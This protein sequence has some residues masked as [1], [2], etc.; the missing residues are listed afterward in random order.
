MDSGPNLPGLPRP[1][2]AACAPDMQ[3]IDLISAVRELNGLSSRELNKLL[4]ESENFTIQFK[5]L[6][7]L[8]EAESISYLDE[9]AGSQKTMHLANSV[10]LEFLDSLKNVFRQEAKQLGDS[11]DKSSRMGLVLLNALRLA[12]IFSDDSNFRSFFMTNTI[13]V[14]AEIFAIP[15]DEFLSSWCSV[16][17]PMIEEDANLDY[18]PFTAAGVALCTL[19]DGCNRIISEPLEIIDMDMQDGTGMGTNLEMVNLGFEIIEMHDL[20]G[21]DYKNDTSS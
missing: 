21:W 2:Q 7:Q 9:V 20:V 14:L 13:P 18:D 10:A 19:N 5:T 12:D 1:R 8:C 4:K 6:L 11:H 17:I 15:H 16:N 3:V